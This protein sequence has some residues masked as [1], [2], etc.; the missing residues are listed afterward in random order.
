MRDGVHLELASTSSYGS[1]P[2][3]Y[4]LPTLTT[5]RGFA[6]GKSP[7]RLLSGVVPCSEPS[8]IVPN[9]QEAVAVSR[10]GYEPRLL[11]TV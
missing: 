10:P 11:P 8:R 7:P 5:L 4:N 3:G 1:T 6:L 9:A 2:I